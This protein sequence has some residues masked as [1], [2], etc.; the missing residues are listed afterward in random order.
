[1]IKSIP[2]SLFHH[3]CLIFSKIHIA[4]NHFT[5]NVMNLF[6]EDEMVLEEG[7]WTD[8]QDLEYIYTE[9]EARE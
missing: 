5:D 8:H 4:F 7:K 2:G 3:F 9:V 1:M 6:A